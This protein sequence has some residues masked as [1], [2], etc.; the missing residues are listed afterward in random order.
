MKSFEQYCVPAPT[1]NSLAREADLSLPDGRSVKVAGAQLDFRI[2]SFDA[3]RAELDKLVSIYERA[4]TLAT[5]YVG[6]QGL[7]AAMGSRLLSPYEFRSFA[8]ILAELKTGAFNLPEQAAFDAFL[9]AQTAAGAMLARPRMESVAGAEKIWT[10]TGLT[11]EAQHDL[12][13]M[14]RSYEQLLDVVLTFQPL[15][16]VASQAPQGSGSGAGGLSSTVTGRWIDTF[17]D[18]LEKYVQRRRVIDR[19]RLVLRLMPRKGAYGEVPTGKKGRTDL[20]PEHPVRMTESYRLDTLDD[21]YLNV[22][23]PRFYLREDYL[24]QLKHQGFG[25]GRQLYSMS[26]LPEEE[27]VITVKSFKGTTVTESES[28][29]ENIFEEQG[30]ETASDFARELQ[31]EN[32]SESSDSSSISVSAKASA[33]YG[34]ASGSVEAG[35]NAQSS[36]REFSK[37]MSSTTER[38][39]SE[40]LDRDQARQD[41]HHRRAHRP[42]HGAQDQEPEQGP[43]A[44]VQ[45]VPDDAQVLAAALAG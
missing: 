31:K 32:Q 3:L 9:T 20:S 17:Q 29:A 39:A 19:D 35:Y 40:R 24:L 13:G 21:K 34:C 5:S 2:R 42:H 26:L 12:E 14:V 30:A 8:Y 1:H 22:A 6:Q 33:S 18:L 41:H 36:S 11:A 43:H 37:N 15:T 44:D 45:L 7:W 25:I 4:W 23:D 28:S 16:A 10:Q 38:L 27:Q